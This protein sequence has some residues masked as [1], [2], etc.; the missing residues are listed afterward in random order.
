[1]KNTVL[2]IVSLTIVVIMMLFSIGCGLMSGSKDIDDTSLTSGEN[3]EKVTKQTHLCEDFVTTDPQPRPYPDFEGLEI[4]IL[5]SDSKDISKEWKK[6]ITE[7]DLDLAVGLRNDSVEEAL[8]IKLVWN[9]INSNCTYTEYANRFYDTIQTDVDS[10]KHQYDISAGP[11]YASTSL[12]IRDY[13]ANMF[14]FELFP[15]FDFELP[16]W[17]KEIINNCTVNGRLHY[18][19]GSINISH[20]DSAIVMWHNKTLYDAKT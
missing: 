19:A 10:G 1:M 2:R 14:D 18:V 9:P 20:I 7:D 4:S 11:A 16:C 6:E 13:T 5:Y 3:T 8:N 17:N 12:E 15:G